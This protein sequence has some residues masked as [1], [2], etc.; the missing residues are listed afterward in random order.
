[1]RARHNVATQ[2]TTQLESVGYQ[3]V[4]RS[5]QTASGPTMSASLDISILA[6]SPSP[7]STPFAREH[8]PS[9][10]LPEFLREHLDVAFVGL[11]LGRRSAGT[12]DYYADAGNCFWATL[13]RVGMTPRLYQ[14]HEAPRACELGVGFVDLARG[15]Y[16]RNGEAA[17]RLDRAGFTHTLERYQP[18]A[19]AFTGKNAA[20]LWLRRSGQR[21]KYGQQKRRSSDGHAVFV[22]PSPAA[23]ARRY[24]RV[25]PWHE[26]ADWLRATVPWRF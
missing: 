3:H 1:V 10:I 8:E 11:S 9:A 15:S 12:L 17:A 25:E 4:S 5:K 2:R 22:L 13:H 16:G 6:H 26:L 7:V 20:C 23:S 19:I 21:M 24:W 18:R 14:P